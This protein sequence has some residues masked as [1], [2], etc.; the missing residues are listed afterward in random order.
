M[1]QKKQTIEIK[2]VE[3]FMAN[4][5]VLAELG[6]SKPDKEVLKTYKGFGGLR[7]CFNSKQLYGMLMREI[8]NN[9]GK[10][11][12]HEVFNTLRHSC[13]SA[14]YTPKEVINFMYRYL[15]EVCDF[16]GGAILEPSCGNGTFFEHILPTH[17]IA[18]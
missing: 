5:A 16:K 1:E 14:Y 15:V 17:L 8:R 13:K 3:Q 10:E 7:Q 18:P 6:Q 2:K 12:E 11:R 4:V 9:F